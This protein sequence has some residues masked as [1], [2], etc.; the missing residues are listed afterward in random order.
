MEILVRGGVE[1]GRE[2]SGGNCGD[3]GKGRSGNGKTKHRGYEVVKL[4]TKNHLK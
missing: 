3:F 4:R 2:K 1:M